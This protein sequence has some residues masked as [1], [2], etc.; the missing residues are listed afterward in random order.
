MR[1]FVALCPALTGNPAPAAWLAAAS[2]GGLCP[3]L[4]LPVRVTN[5]PEG[6]FLV[7]ECLVCRCNQPTG[8]LI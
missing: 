3:A 8:R 2:P 1:A 7:G 4:L 6:L 5:Q